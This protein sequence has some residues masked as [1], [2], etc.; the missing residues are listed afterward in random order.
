MALL[1]IHAAT[2]L[3][4]MMAL[5]HLLRNQPQDDCHD[6][7]FWRSRSTVADDDWM[8]AE[9]RASYPFYRL[10]DAK[11]LQYGLPRQAGAWRWPFQLARRL[12]NDRA[13][14]M[15]HLRPLNT[16]NLQVELWTME[17]HDVPVTLLHAMFSGA[18]R[19]KVPELIGA[20]YPSCAH[21]CLSFCRAAIKRDTNARRLFNAMVGIFSGVWMSPYN[22][23]VYD[24]A[25]TFNR[26]ST[27][28]ANCVDLSSTIAPAP[29]KAT[30]D[31]LP[32]ALRERIAQA[33][34]EAS[35]GNNSPW[36]LMP[37]F[38]IVDERSFNMWRL[39]LLRVHNEN[40]D[41]FNGA[42]VVLKPHPQSPNDAPERL[43]AALASAIGQPVGLFNVTFPLDFLWHV[44]PV[45]AV[46]A[47]PTG[48]I[49]VLQRLGNPPVYILREVFEDLCDSKPW[50][51]DM[52]W[53]VEGLQMLTRDCKFI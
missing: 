37:L 2:G 27:W 50:S 3:H 41:V 25:Y 53:A 4:S 23:L 18:K 42:R 10:V 32:N 36:I 6:I 5:V 28:A 34:N 20:E 1:R 7:L 9:V 26:Q 30:Y 43:A 38:G 45:K 14:I 47:G 8:F 39:C 40:P 24:K 49:P 13:K 52:T 29:L 46:L 21:V 35:G 15:A 12:R 11:E 48:G 16:K 22:G 19:V 33:I 51:E 44:L 17:P 31:S